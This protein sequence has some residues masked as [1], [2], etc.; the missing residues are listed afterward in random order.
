MPSFSIIIPWCNRKEL[1]VTLE[2]NLPLFEKH[3]AEVIISNI[4]GNTEL[5]Q[6]ILQP[7]SYPFKVVQRTDIAVFNK[8][9]ALNMGVSVAGG[10]YLFLLDTDIMLEEDLLSAAAVL[11]ETDC[12][13]TIGKVYES[14]KSTAGGKSFIAELAYFIEIKDIHDNSAVIETSRHYINEK[15]RSAPGLVL[16]R[17]A[18]FLAVNGMN[19]ALSGWGWEDNDLLCRLQLKLS[20]KWKKSG[21]AIHLTHTDQ[22]RV[23]NNNSRKA[24]EAANYAKCLDNYSQGN[25]TGTYKEDIQ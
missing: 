1:S 23:I 25:Y 21:S 3:A 20:L 22:Q 19:T 11:L 13:V 17:K 14:E 16:L 4:G 12:F 15:G 6:E 10:E 5:L 7:F 18:H 24:S 2:K 9:L 8:C